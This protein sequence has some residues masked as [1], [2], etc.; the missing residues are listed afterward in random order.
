MKPQDFNSKKHPFLCVW[1]FGSTSAH[2]IQPE[3]KDRFLDAL[4]EQK[5]GYFHYT[6]V[7]GAN[8]GINLEHVSGWLLKT[9]EA[10]ALSNADHQRWDEDQATKEP[11]E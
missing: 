9:P 10:V 11:W 5:F 7:F 4:R 2:L 6:D 1:T 8:G 3:D